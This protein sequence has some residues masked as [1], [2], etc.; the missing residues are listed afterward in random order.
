MSFDSMLRLKAAKKV[1]NPRNANVSVRHNFLITLRKL[2]FTKSLDVRHH[3]VI[4]I[5]TRLIEIS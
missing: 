1:G 3:T 5:D 2:V 4:E